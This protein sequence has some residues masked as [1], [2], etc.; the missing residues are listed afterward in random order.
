MNKQ[1]RYYIDIDEFCIEKEF[2]KELCDNYISMTQSTS[3]LKCHVI[4]FLVHKNH[5]VQ[6]V[7]SSILVLAT[8]SNIDLGEFE[9]VRTFKKHDENI[10]SYILL[11]NSAHIDLFKQ[12]FK[13]IIEQQ[14]NLFKILPK[15]SIDV[16]TCHYQLK[17]ADKITKESIEIFHWIQDNCKSNVYKQNDVWFFESQDDAVAFKLQWVKN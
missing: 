7:I 12:S 2:S 13:Y 5:R 11:K 1:E 10:I 4:E 16:T 3:M 14:Y 15:H 9:I 8:I 17:S 6:E